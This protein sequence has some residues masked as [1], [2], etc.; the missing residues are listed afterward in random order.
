[1][2]SPRATHFAMAVAYLGLAALFGYLAWLRYFRW[3]DCF[4]ELGRCYSPDDSGEVYTTGGLGWM[5]PAIVF[6]VL[7]VRRLVRA[8]RQA[9]S[10]RRH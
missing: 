1:M 7:A 2:L 5:L 8:R 6:A 10:R 9:R 4:N 3:A